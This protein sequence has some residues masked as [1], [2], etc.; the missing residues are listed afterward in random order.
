MTDWGRLETLTGWAAAF[1][2]KR[3]LDLVATMS[4]LRSQSGHPGSAQAKAGYDPKP[5]YLFKREIEPVSHA[6]HII[7]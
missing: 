6:G 2:P 5:T 1:G 4:A 7:D 3:S